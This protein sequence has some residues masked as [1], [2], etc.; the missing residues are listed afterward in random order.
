MMLNKTNCQS[1]GLMGG[2]WPMNAAIY[3]RPSAVIL[4]VW[5]CETIVPVTQTEEHGVQKHGQVFEQ[6]GCA[7][8]QTRL[9]SKTGSL[10]AHEL[11][12]KWIRCN[13]CWDCEI[14]NEI[15]LNYSE[16]ISINFNSTSLHSNLNWS[17]ASCLLP[18]NQ[19]QEFIWNLECTERTTLIEMSSS[20]QGIY[21]AYYSCAS[22]LH[23]FS[24]YSTVFHLI[25]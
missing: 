18:S 9:N 7:K 19:M 8:F 24:K 3:S 12:F 10:S 15:Y 22:Y 16:I 11:E 23:P 13:T 17:S 25:D 5:L 14:W 2:P 6:E 20:T 21:C 4:K 1:N